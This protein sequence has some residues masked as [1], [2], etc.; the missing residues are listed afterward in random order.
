VGRARV[1]HHWSTVHHIHK[2]GME[3]KSAW[4]RFMCY[5][6]AMAFVSISMCTCG[7]VH[8]RK[9]AGKVS[10]ANRKFQCIV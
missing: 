2:Q 4:I 7:Q 3:G 10:T 5:A 9:Q 6:K 8:V 1:T